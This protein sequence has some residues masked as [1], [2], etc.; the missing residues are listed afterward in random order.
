MIKMYCRI[1]NLIYIASSN[2]YGAYISII[3][4]DKKI[5]NFSSNILCIFERFWR[6]SVLN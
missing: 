5:S 3:V 6:K 4:I 2:G 1:Y